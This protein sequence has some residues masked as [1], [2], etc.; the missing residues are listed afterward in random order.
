MREVA[1]QQ[2]HIEAEVEKSVVLLEDSRR[3]GNCVEGSLQF[4]ER[5]LGL[6]R[7]AVLAGQWFVSVPGCRLLATGDRRAEMAVRAAFQRETTIAI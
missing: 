7:E 6:P 5:R 4:A 1:R 2:E 3:A